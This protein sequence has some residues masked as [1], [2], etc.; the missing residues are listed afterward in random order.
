MKYII[1]SFRWHTV[2]NQW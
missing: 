1:G 2:V